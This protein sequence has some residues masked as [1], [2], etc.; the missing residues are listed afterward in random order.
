[1]TTTSPPSS[2]PLAAP[3]RTGA[4][5]AALAAVRDLR[6]RARRRMTLALGGL[7]VVLVGLLAVRVL[8]GQYTIT[9]PDFVRILGGKTIPG[10]SYIVMESKLPR[11]VGAALAGAAFG[12]S[13]ALFRRT[14]RNPL[15]SPD[16]LGISGGAAAGAVSA[17][18]LF[19]APGI[20]MAIG[21]LVGGLVT[22]GIV[23]A[24]ARSGPAAS[25]GATSAMGSETVIVAG[26]A[27]AALAQVLV[28]QL[29]LGLDRWDLQTVAVWTSGSLGMATWT[30]ITALALALVVLLPLAGAVHAALAPADLGADLA[31]GLGAR[32]E[33]WGFAALVVGALLASAAT[34]AFGPLAFVALLATP[35]A[36]G[37]TGGVPS[38]PASAL[39]GAVIVVLADFLASE[40][41]P[42]VRLPT[43]ILT[44]AA[45]APL[46]LWLLLRSKARL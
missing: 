4:G 3:S 22:A 37:L 44:G 24:F 1:M 13:G 43:G 29:V 38:L 8:L 23:L 27:I 36:R 21:A 26:I 12:A 46:M 11:A 40:L 5:P 45:G 34:A 31:H 28:A 2:A 42:G 35:L 15:A 39:V 7:A 19:D 17:L 20:G 18:A 33:R 30:R 41:V 32:P 25:G 14:L 10:A 9:I 6:G 16:L